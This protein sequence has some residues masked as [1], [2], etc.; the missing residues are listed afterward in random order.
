M[1]ELVTA[2]DRALSDTDLFPV[3][4]AD[5]AIGWGKVSVA[6]ARSAITGNPVLVQSVND[7]RDAAGVRT[8]QLP[9]APT[10]GNVLVFIYTGTTNLFTLPA[11]W[12]V[13]DVK[14]Y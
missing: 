5:G 1:T 10:V 13:A 11:G 6:D 14:K 4:D 12:M 3:T 9:S 2:P 7:R 8:W